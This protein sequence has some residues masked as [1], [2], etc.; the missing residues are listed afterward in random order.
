MGKLVAAVEQIASKQGETK[1]AQ[2]QAVVPLLFEC[3]DGGVS[4]CASAVAAG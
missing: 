4:G 2:T 1:V 3:S